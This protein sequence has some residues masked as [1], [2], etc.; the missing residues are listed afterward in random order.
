M[1]LSKRGK[2]FSN[3]VKAINKYTSKDSG[4]VWYKGVAWDWRMVKYALEELKTKKDENESKKSGN[5]Q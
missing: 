1:F 3:L 4:L 2:N 5:M